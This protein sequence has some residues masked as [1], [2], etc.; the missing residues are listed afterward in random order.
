MEKEDITDV[1]NRKGGQ[2][3]KDNECYV[4]KRTKILPLKDKNCRNMSRQRFDSSVALFTLLHHLDT[5]TAEGRITEGRKCSVQ[6]MFHSTFGHFLPSG[7]YPNT[8]VNI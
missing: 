6:I 3:L 1:P 7:K 8:C 5:E 4:Y 2:N